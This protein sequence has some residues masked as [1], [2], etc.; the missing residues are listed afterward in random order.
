MERPHPGG[1]AGRAMTLAADLRSGKDHR[2]ENFPVASLLIAARHRKPIMAFYEFVRTADDIAD[3]ATLAPAEKLKLLDRLEATLLGQSDAEPEGVAL[4]EVLAER[5]LS[6]QH[7]QDLL[8]AFRMDV[9][10]LRYRDFDDL[11]NYCRYSAMPVGRFVLD[12][13]GEDRASWPANDALCAALQIINHLQD[14]GADYRNLD[15]V[16]LPLDILAAHGA[17][18]EDLKRP[19]ATP[20]L[21]AALN[22]ICERLDALLDQSAAFAG[23]IKDRGLSL[24]VSVIQRLAEKLTRMLR[25]HDPLSE[26]VHLGKLE[27]AGVTVLGLMQGASRR[28]T[29]RNGAANDATTAATAASGSS[30]YAAMRI[31]PRP[32]RQAMYDVYAF[33]RAVD[34]IADEAG[35]RGER[36]ARLKQWRRDIDAIYAGAPPARLA[37]LAQAV[38][39][40]GLAREDFLAVIDGMEMDVRADIRAPD[41][42]TLDLYCDRVASAVGRLS[43]RIFG[44]NEKDGIDLARE[45]GRALQLT[46]TLRDL[47]E[48]AGIGRLYLPRELLVE[49]G[50]TGTDPQAVLAHPALGR[51]CAA[52]AARAEKH[53]ERAD[54]IMAAS[55]RAVVRA[56]RIMG[57]AYK[58]ILR[59]LLARGWASP[60]ARVK[61]GK[62][63]FAQILLRSYIA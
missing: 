49:A 23:Q 33:C 14:C 25:A 5:A 34:D 50:I 52:V 13:H 27:V 16:Y 61:L 62:R 12:V 43:V 39:A 53:F 10:K 32:Q 59:R 18:V 20:H 55:P 41:L 3:H 11:M 42:A 8:N 22:E 24:E 9:T 54:A 40:F 63:Q 15:R 56:P 44:M 6:P 46:N 17:S 29:G 47:D 58:R 2:G 35:D 38:C 30:F 21:R 28:L 60:R 48:D 57:E 45:L 4:R 37:S 7:A 1:R 51:A 36:L 31:L 26:R 19:A